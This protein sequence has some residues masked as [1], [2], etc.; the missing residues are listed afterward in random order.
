MSLIR[1][2]TEYTSHTERRSLAQPTLKRAQ[3]TYVSL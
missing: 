2:S 1:K 3:N